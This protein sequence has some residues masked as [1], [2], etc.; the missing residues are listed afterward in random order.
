MLGLGL[1]HSLPRLFRRHRGAC[2]EAVAQ[3][4]F[5]IVTAGSGAEGL[6]LLREEPVAGWPLA[7]GAAGDGLVATWAQYVSP[8]GGGI[9][10]LAAERPG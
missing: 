9:R 2:V 5:R 10:V 8:E 3:R 6:K 4:S 7:V 1:A